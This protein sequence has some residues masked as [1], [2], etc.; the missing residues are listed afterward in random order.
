MNPTTTAVATAAGERAKPRSGAHLLVLTRLDPAQWERLAATAAAAGKVL[1]SRDEESAL[2]SSLPV[3]AILGGPP[4]ELLDGLHQVDWV[5]LRTDCL[6]SWG[7]CLRDLHE[8]R[9]VVTRTRG[10]YNETAPDHA[11][12]L[13]LAMARD[14][15]TLLRQQALAEWRNEDVHPVVL[16]QATLGLVGFGSIGVAIAQRAAAFGMTILAT[17]PEPFARP[18]G[19]TIYPPEE[20]PTLLAASDFVVVTVP[21]CERTEHLLDA[22]AFAAMKPGAALINIGRGRVVDTAALLAALDRGQLAGAALDVVDPQPLPESHPL[23]RHP[24]V[25]L[26]A[27]SAPKGS[28]FAEAQFEQILDNVGRYL[29]G[30]PLR[31]VIAPPI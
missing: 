15:P 4:P 18:E 14:L 28:H 19:V 20:L 10:S 3:T 31:H 9:I 25:L 27:H 21:Y 5:Q 22:A 30:E 2:R 6:E 17:D 29:R 16:S 1:L 11:L 7:D 26:T 23:W 12:L 13:L 8:R 24:R